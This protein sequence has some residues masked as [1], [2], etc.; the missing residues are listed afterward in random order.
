MYYPQLCVFLILPS[1][2]FLSYFDVPALLSLTTIFPCLT[3]FL[4]CCVFVFFVL[5]H[6]ILIR[7]SSDFHLRR[8]AFNQSM[9]DERIDVHS[10][11]LNIFSLFPSFFQ[12]NILYFAFSACSCASS[13]NNSS[14]NCCCTLFLI[15]NDRE[16]QFFDDYFYWSACAA[17][18]SFSLACITYSVSALFV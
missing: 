4:L 16:R 17:F 9:I 7:V 8:A 15:K 2:I 11:I 10:F 3:T 13:R 18:H 12:R 5:F 14:I 6:P 1:T